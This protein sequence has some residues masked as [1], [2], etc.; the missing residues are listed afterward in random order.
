MRSPAA[1]SHSGSPADGGG[2]G[3]GAIVD[4]LQLTSED[5]EIDVR[6]FFDGHITEIFFMGGRVAM[7][8]GIKATESSGFTIFAEGAE[9][10]EVSG[11]EAWHMGSIWVP[12]SEQVDHPATS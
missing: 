8:V 1:P 7:T 12:K 2:S 9:A 11:V 5:E 4:T 3:G 6:V 10:V